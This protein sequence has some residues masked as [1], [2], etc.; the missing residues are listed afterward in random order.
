MLNKRGMFIDKLRS[1]IIYYNNHFVRGHNGSVRIR[2]DSHHDGTGQVG[3][4]GCRACG[5]VPAASCM[6]SGIKG[7]K[8]LSWHAALKIQMPVG[9]LLGHKG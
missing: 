2:T 4:F 8:E 6:H 1:I 7:H 5:A 9:R 3:A